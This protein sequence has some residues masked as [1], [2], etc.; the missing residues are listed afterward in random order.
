M[1]FDVII[2]I[3]PTNSTTVDS[4]RVPPD[5]SAVRK[6]GEVLDPRYLSLVILRDGSW[7]R[8]LDDSERRCSATTAYVRWMT[9]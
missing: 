3:R 4:G 5:I 2:A 9:I 7:R 8:G 1:Q 6:S